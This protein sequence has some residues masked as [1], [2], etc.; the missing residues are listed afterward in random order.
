MTVRTQ[1]GSFESAGHPTEGTRPG[2]DIALKTHGD[3][4][5]VFE[6]RVYGE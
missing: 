4:A 3:T 1:I 2:G 6:V 5:R